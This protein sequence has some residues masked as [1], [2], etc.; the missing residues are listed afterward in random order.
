MMNINELQFSARS[1]NLLRRKGIM[2]V[3][4]LLAMTDEE[5]IALYDG[6]KAMGEIIEVITPL[7]KNQSTSK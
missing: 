1:Y 5:F 4:Q 2:E 3:E 6:K 7:R